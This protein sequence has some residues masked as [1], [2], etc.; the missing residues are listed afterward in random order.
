MKPRHCI[1]SLTQPLT[2]SQVHAAHTYSQTLPA[3]FLMGKSLGGLVLYFPFSVISV[4][5]LVEIIFLSEALTKM[6]A[7]CYEFWKW[8]SASLYVF[9]LY[10][11]HFF[12]FCSLSCIFFPLHLGP[13][14][15]NGDF[16]IQRLYSPKH[17][18][19]TTVYSSW[20]HATY[21][22]V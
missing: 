11:P 5:C 16:E 18:P 17:K 3:I 8:P 12:C 15:F 21:L 2:R 4:D 19:N 22:L 9:Y 20:E 6:P 13:S 7:L 10:S 14:H 1:I